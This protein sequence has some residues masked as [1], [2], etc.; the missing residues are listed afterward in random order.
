MCDLA[1]KYTINLAVIW[2]NELNNKINLIFGLEFY[3]NINC[4][5]RYQNIIVEPLF[6]CIYLK[7]KCQ[8]LI[9]RS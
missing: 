7:W 4:N 1:A 3:C 8:V 6:L 2:I 5:N 9:L